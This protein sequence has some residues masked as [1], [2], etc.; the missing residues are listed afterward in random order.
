MEVGRQPMVDVKGVDG[1][2]GHMQ[3]MAQSKL[4]GP[5]DLRTG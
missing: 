4:K 5:F 1:Q 2:E 3:Q